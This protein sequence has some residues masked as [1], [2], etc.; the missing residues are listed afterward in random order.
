MHNIMSGF[1]VPSGSDLQAG[2][3]AGFGSTILVASKSSC[4]GWIVTDDATERGNKFAS[5]LSDLGLSESD[6]LG[7]S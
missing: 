4:G 2:H 1:Y 3:T 5:L 7:C 6:N